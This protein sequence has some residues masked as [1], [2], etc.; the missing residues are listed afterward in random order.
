MRDCEHGNAGRKIR[1]KRREE[2]AG[3]DVWRFFLPAVRCSFSPSRSPVSSRG[4]VPSPRRIS[5]CLHFGFWN[6]SS[7]HSV[8]VV[9]FCPRRFH[10]VLVEFLE[11]RCL[12]S[13]AFPEKFSSIHE[14]LVRRP[15]R[16]F[17]SRAKSGFPSSGGQQALSRRSAVVGPA[18]AA[19]VRP[20]SSDPALLRA[21]QPGRVE[22]GSPPGVVRS[23]VAVQS[24]CSLASMFPVQPGRA[25][26]WAEGVQLHEVPAQLRHQFSPV[27][28]PV[29]QRACGRTKF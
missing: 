11:R 2:P 9:S 19:V 18:S 14:Y 15:L 28:R 27:G 1:G 26:S 10:S 3:W 4:F 20:G 7:F 21:L 6:P 5:G 25:P 17:F 29:G 13:G 24:R 16:A 23:H 22:A 8:L 12:C